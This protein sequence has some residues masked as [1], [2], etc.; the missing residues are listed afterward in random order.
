MRSNDLAFMFEDWTAPQFATAGKNMRRILKEMQLVDSQ[1]TMYD[2]VS[3][4]S[5][6]KI[7]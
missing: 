2:I 5:H 7:N 1:M 6:M 4:T 3:N